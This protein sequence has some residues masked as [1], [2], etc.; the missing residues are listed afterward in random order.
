[1]DTMDEGWF[2]KFE[3][4]AIELGLWGEEPN[5]WSLYS[6]EGSPYGLAACKKTQRAH[7]SYQLS[8]RGKALKL[9]AISKTVPWDRTQESLTVPWARHG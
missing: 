7:F 9:N 3:T 6:I 5:A 2:F 8:F 1:M 4:G